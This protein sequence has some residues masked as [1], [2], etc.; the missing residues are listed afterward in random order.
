MA[1]LPPDPVN[2]A[3]CLFAYWEQ[4][5]NFY[6]DVDRTNDGPFAIETI[7]ELSILV[8]NATS[9]HL[10]QQKDEGEDNLHNP[11]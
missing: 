11:N 3:N 10:A 1:S 9:Q 4:H 7:N 6:E 5:L 8:A 2:L